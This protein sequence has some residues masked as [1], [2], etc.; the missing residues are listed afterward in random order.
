MSTDTRERITARVLDT[1]NAIEGLIGDGS[2][3]LSEGEDGK[4]TELR[5]SLRGDRNAL[6]ALPE[7]PQPT[8]AATPDAD[9]VELRAACSLTNFVH[10]AVSGRL[11]GAEAEYAAETDLSTGRVPLA[12]FETETRAAPVETRAIS[13]S[14]ATV[15]V[16][17]DPILPAIFARSV[18]DRL[19][20]HMPMVGS[21]TY[22]TGTITTSTTAAAKLKAN[23]DATKV[24]AP[25]TAA[26]ISVNTTTPHR[27]SARLTVALEDIAAIG[28]DNFEAILRQNLML[29][30]SAEL[31]N[32][33]LNGDSTAADG[34][35]P[36]GLLKQLTDPTGNPAALA[37]WLDYVK[38]VSDGTDGGP[39]A[40]GMNAVRLCVNAETMRHADTTFRVPEGAMASG[41][42]TPGE[43]SAAAYLRAHSGGFFSSSRMPATAS[44]VAQAIR[45]RPGTNGLDGVNAV[46][47][48]VCPV[49]T[50]VAIDDITTDSA[51]GRRHLT[52]HVLI[53]DVLVVQAAA[54]EQI[55]LQVS[56]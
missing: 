18:C 43:M 40:E 2:S 17:L 45:Y 42:A 33:C 6:A 32:L 24:N 41:Y 3:P 23:S 4:L 1:Q 28:T 38:A 11:T 25:A 39:W 46:R 50:E 53:G 20:I 51:S 8:E 26:A 44:N 56:T 16:N 29:A 36:D 37:T 19:G 31:D 22:A 35:Q 34:E 54:Y 49:W 14:P 10:G 9:R 52:F 55:E 21:G 5:Q 30:M 27:V 12:M 13:P 48:A 47:T 7:Y 15:G